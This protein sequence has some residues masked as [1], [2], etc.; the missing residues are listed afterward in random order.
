MNRIITFETEEEAKTTLANH[1]EKNKNAVRE[2]QET[3]NGRIDLARIQKR[4]EMSWGDLMSPSAIMLTEKELQ[5][6]AN[7]AGIGHELHCPANVY[8]FE[9]DNKNHYAC[10]YSITNLYGEVFS[11]QHTD[12]ARLAKPV[13][14]MAKLIQGLYKGATVNPVVY[15][16]KKEDILTDKEKDAL[17]RLINDTLSCLPNYLP[18]KEVGNTLLRGL[19]D[20]ERLVLEEALNTIR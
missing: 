20:Q 13:R 15:T 11:Q 9:E 1:I 2:I 5:E 6:L 10:A 8:A 4:K 16:I 12:V 7:D 14:G 19:N 18:K 3:I 17:N